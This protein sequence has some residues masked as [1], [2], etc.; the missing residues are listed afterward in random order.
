M[1]IYPKYWGRL[2]GTQIIRPRPFSGAAMVLNQFLFFGAFLFKLSQSVYIDGPCP[3]APRTHKLDIQNIDP[4]FYLKYLAPAASSIA[5]LQL[6]RALEATHSHTGLFH[7]NEGIR[8]QYAQFPQ[9]SCQE[10]LG[11]ISMN[12]SSQS[13][14]YTYMIVALAS[15]NDRIVCF[16]N[17]EY[18][19][20]LF[21]WEYKGYRIFYTCTGSEYNSG[22]DEA[23]MILHRM[24][25]F[26][27]VS[28]HIP[29]EELRKKFLGFSNLTTKDSVTIAF[30]LRRPHDCVDYECPKNTQYNLILLGL[31]LVG[32]QAMAV[33]FIKYY[34][35]YCK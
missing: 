26:E 2:I 24:H 16:D 29:L 28:T 13:L 35:W 6:F 14:D 5:E 7:I 34:G 27:N 3:V 9:M 18:K 1:F 8:F 12:E 31:L 21:L 22:H 23:V 10:I 33:V 17:I 15:G 30:G 4:N 20:R 32:L 25:D 11:E 19:I